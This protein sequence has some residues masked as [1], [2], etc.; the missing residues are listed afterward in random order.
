MIGRLERQKYRTGY[1]WQWLTPGCE[2]IAQIPGYLTWHVLMAP[3]GNEHHPFSL[4]HISSGNWWRRKSGC[5]R[6]WNDQI[7]R[8]CCGFVVPVFTGRSENIIYPKLFKCSAQWTSLCSSVQK[9]KFLGERAL[10]LSRHDRVVI[11]WIYKFKSYFCLD[12]R[13]TNLNSYR[14]RPVHRPDCWSIGP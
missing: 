10:N 3:W 5:I 14:N 7:E 1:W 6:N 12:A 9:K 11:Y 8:G 2:T 4:S 13:W